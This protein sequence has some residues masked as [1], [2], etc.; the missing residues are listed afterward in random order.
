MLLEFLA[1]PQAKERQV[2][3]LRRSLKN[4][5]F[6]AEN[7][8]PSRQFGAAFLIARPDPHIEAE[9]AFLR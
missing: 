1:S 4:N 8:A 5:E 3:T 2:S 9:E 7:Q 6:H